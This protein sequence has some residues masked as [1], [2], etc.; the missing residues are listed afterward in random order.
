MDVTGYKI[1]PSKHCILGW[2]R[3]WD[4]DIDTVRKMIE[5]AY[6]LEKIGKN[7]Y[8]SYTRIKGKG[9]KLIFIKDEERKELFIITGAEGS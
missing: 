7:K 9:R 3:K 5:E 2:L 6:K 1:R 4:A 8:E